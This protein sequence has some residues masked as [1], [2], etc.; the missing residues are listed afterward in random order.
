MK[1]HELFWGVYFLWCFLV[2][3]VCLFF[4]S[5]FTLSQDLLPSATPTRPARHT[6]RFHRDVHRAA[7]TR[8][9]FSIVQI[10]SK[11]RIY[12]KDARDV[13][14]VMPQQHALLTLQALISPLLR[15]R[16]LP[17]QNKKAINKTTKTWNK[18]LSDNEEGRREGGSPWVVPCNCLHRVA[19]QRPREQLG[20]G[21][22]RLP[23]RTCR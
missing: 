1:H 6:T 3:F 5:L 7:F 9:E 22:T 11:W 19:Q 8:S 23:T 4:K 2:G 15:T 20:H 21:C 14:H 13:N 17:S 10:R 18:E 16:V 12:N